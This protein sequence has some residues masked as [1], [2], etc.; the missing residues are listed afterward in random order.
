MAG[1]P[2]SLPSEPQ[3]PSASER[4]DS[5]K[6]IAAY[7]KRSVRTVHRWESEQ[8]LPVHRH[9]HQSS[10][11]VYAFRSE[12][13]TW[14]ASRKFELEV[15]AETAEEPPSAVIPFRPVTGF[16]RWLMVA[17]IVVSVAALGS[18]AYWRMHTSRNV[19]A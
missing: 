6:E 7:L 15:A 8:G 16:I 13:D 1:T 2:Q 18:I 17:G 9:L 10:G 3:K 19:I 5:W 11:T 4:L 14:W 12:L